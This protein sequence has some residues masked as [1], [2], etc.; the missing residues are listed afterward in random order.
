MFEVGLKLRA[1]QE[2]GGLPFQRVSRLVGR[3][4]LSVLLE[5]SPSKSQWPCNA[6]WT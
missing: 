6:V 3:N 5:G 4:G 1:W 2:K